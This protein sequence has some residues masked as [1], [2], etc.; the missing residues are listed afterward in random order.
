MHQSLMILHLGDMRH[1]AKEEGYESQC[2]NGELRGSPSGEAVF[3]HW[4]L[5]LQ[6]GWAL[7]L[8]GRERPADNML[9]TGRQVSV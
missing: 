3:V 8:L 9:R 1:D 7:L 6:Y 4:P 5:D 2:A